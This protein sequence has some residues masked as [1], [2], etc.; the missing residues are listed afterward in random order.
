MGLCVIAGAKTLTLAVSVFT[1]SWMH[2]VEHTGWQ[3]DY[4][5]TPAHQLRITEARV[6]GSGAGMD[7][8]EGSVLKDDWWVYTPKLK[9]IPA[10]HLGSSGA[11][12]DGWHLCSPQMKKCLDLG[13][14]PGKAITVKPCDQG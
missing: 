14:K 13:E 1:L 7:P 10:L 3:E 4:K 8:P 6:K 5:I 2:S 9:P 11:T 12:G